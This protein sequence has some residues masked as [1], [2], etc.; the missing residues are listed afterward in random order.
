MSD[1]LGHGTDIVQ[2]IAGDGDDGAAGVARGAEVVVLRCFSESGGG[3]VRLLVQAITDAVD[4]YGCNVINMSWGVKAKSEALYRAIR[5]AYEA[6]AILVAAAGNVEAQFPQGTL[7][8]PAT[9]GE[10]IG[11]GAVNDDLSVAGYSQKTEAVTV[12]APGTV[13]ALVGRNGEISLKYGTSYAA[14]CI[15]AMAAI[16]KGLAP[17]MEPEDILALLRS[18]AEDLGD[19]GYDTA[20]GYGF[21]RIDRLLAEPWRAVRYDNDEPVLYGWQI[22]DGGSRVLIA[23]YD[24][25][26]RL[27]DVSILGSEEAVFRF[28]YA[29]PMS[30]DA[31]EYAA[32]CLN[33]AYVPLTESLRFST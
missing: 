31:Q 33:G 32:L 8:Y 16:V 1:D 28:E 19:A 27:K 14:P 7:V 11:V 6:G 25:A 4:M 12:C 9:W 21:L 13:G 5:H 3:T 20:Y 26:G 22:S 10:V 15:A 17:F 24:D 23:I 2:I 18:R 29:F 30:Q